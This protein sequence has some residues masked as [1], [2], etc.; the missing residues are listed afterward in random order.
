MSTDE[1]TLSKKNQ[2]MN[3]LLWFW[4]LKGEDYNVNQHHNYVLEIELTKSK[5]KKAITLKK[6][7]NLFSRQ[8]FVEECG[9]GRNS[10]LRKQM[11]SETRNQF[12]SCTFTGTFSTEPD[13]RVNLLTCKQQTW[14]MTVV[15]DKVSF[16]NISSICINFHWRIDKT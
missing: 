12:D 11:S 6:K 5:Q 3:I 7:K 9:R 8:C 1:W 4:H 13:A 15:S 10:C 14:T 2:I 16:Q